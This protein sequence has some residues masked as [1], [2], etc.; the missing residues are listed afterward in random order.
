MD[1]ATTIALVASAAACVSALV[2]LLAIV[3]AN[4]QARLA[5]ESAEKTA[6][7]QVREDRRLE[8]LDRTRRDVEESVGRFVGWIR[9]LEYMMDPFDDLLANPGRELWAGYTREELREELS[10][11]GELFDGTT[12]QCLAAEARPPGALT[13]PMREEAATA[14]FYTSPWGKH[15]RLQLLTVED[16]LAGKGIDCPPLRHTSQ[17]FKKAPK[18]AAGVEAASLFGPDP[19]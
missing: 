15:P 19:T 3:L 12:L 16:L 6:L 11:L 2:A 4:R 7:A 13:K 5:R 17:T 10:D 9:E 1:T 14:G 8:L 18:A